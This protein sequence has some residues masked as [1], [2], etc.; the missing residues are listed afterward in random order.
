LLENICDAAKREGI[1]IWSIGFEVDLHG[2]DIM[3]NCAS[4]PSHYFDVD[5]GTELTDAFKAI[6]GQIHQLRLIQ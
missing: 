1:V 4:S 6:A 2:T 3:K 5:G